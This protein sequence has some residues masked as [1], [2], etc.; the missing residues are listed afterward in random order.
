MS[1]F[2]KKRAKAALTRDQALACI[3]VINTHV[4]SRSLD[5]GLIRVE[6]AVP[7]SPLL[8]AIHRRFSTRSLELPTK[9]LELD[10]LGSFVW[11]NIDGRNST[12]TLIKQLAA[13][14]A[15][16]LNEAE[17]SV[18]MFLRELGKRGLIAFR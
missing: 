11:T 3:P 13:H 6:Y 16:S 12:K 5:S 2:T 1:L 18:T 10:N 9:K 4:H 8:H 7:L 15:L 14:C 17:I